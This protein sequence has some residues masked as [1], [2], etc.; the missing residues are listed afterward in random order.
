[1]PVPHEWRSSLRTLTA[2]S[3]FSLACIAALA[4]GIAASTAI[5]TVVHG[6]LLRPLPFAQPDQ[7]VTLANTIPAAAVRGFPF[8]LSEFTEHR[9]HNPAFAALAAYAPATVTVTGAEAP[10]R[11]AAARVSANFFDVLGVPAAHGRTFV[12]GEDQPGADCAMVL[13]DGYWRSRFGAEPR[14]IGQSLVVDDAVCRVVGIAPADFRLPATADAWLT[15][16]IAVPAGGDLGRQSYRVVG[17]MAAGMSLE[18]ATAG[19][20]DVARRFYAAHPSFYTGAPWQI[21][22]APLADQVVGDVAATLVMLAG[23][24]GLLLAVACA[25]VAQL[26][27]GRLIARDREFAIRAALGAGRG[28]LFVMVLSEAALLSVAA[29]AIGLWLAVFGVEAWL[30]A[31]LSPL[32]RQESIRVDAVTAAFA[33]AVSLVLAVVVAAAALPRLAAAGSADMLRQGRGGPGRA[34]RRLREG[35]VSIQVALT[36]MLVVGAMLLGASLDRLSQVP[37]GFATRDRLVAQVTPPASRYPDAPRAAALQDAIAERIAAL[38]GVRAVGSVSALPLSGQDPRAAFSID[39]WTPDQEGRATDVHYRVVSGDY[40]RAVG[41]RLTAGRWPSPAD[42]REAP[43][44]VVVNES[45]AR[46]FWDEATLA[47]GR[48]ISFDRGTNWYTIAGI[49]ADVKHLALDAADQIEVFV[50]FAQVTSGAM[51]AMT[52][53]VHAGPEA[54]ALP[55]ALRQAVAAVDPRLPVHGIRTLEDVVAASVARPRFRTTLT[56]LFAVAA[57]LL[58][59]VGTF[60]VFAQFVRERAY[61]IAV[62]RALGAPAGAIAGLTLARGAR[63]LGVG[64]ALGMAGAVALSGTIRAQLFGTSPTDPLTYTL[65][66]ATIA[67]VGLLACALPARRAVRIDPLRKLRAE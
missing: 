27:I 38:P 61:E 33:L 65:A 23:A 30:A 47:L 56:G 1:M 51:P 42:G 50:P 40:F 20:R 67:G 10:E 18:G 5:F 21:V 36:L 29:G 52:I 39:G 58:A 32:P 55:E 46:R 35:L 59:A 17:R 16:R 12:A 60:G 43:K 14:T 3:G 6:V 64:M 19:T 66:A 49:A 62:R 48:R 7:L 13:R 28:R 24:V 4:L 15:A 2:H 41:M 26:M 8:S 63:V 25:N 11:L 37:P 22:L 45:F 31:G 57:L 9:D 53:V 44:I 54:G 34:A